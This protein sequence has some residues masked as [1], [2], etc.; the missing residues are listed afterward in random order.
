MPLLAVAVAVAWLSPTAIP[1]IRPE[2]SVSTVAVAPTP[3]ASTTVAVG[4]GRR[5]M[6]ALLI[7]VG[8]ATVIRGRT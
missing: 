7:T 4:T 5:S 2:L 6:A 8:A 3:V 1:V